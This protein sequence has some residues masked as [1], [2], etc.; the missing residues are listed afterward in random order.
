MACNISAI[1]RRRQSP[2]HGLHRALSRICPSRQS[3]GRKPATPASSPRDAS[4]VRHGVGA[5]SRT[6]FPAIPNLS[7]KIPNLPAEIP[8]LSFAGRG[9]PSCSEGRNFRREVWN[10]HFQTSPCKKEA[11]NFPGQVHPAKREASH[12]EE[13]AEIFAASL[14]H[15]RDKSG[16]AKKKLR[17]AGKKCRARHAEPRLQGAGLSRQASGRRSGRSTSASPHLF[18]DSRIKPGG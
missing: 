5:C 9:F 14:I 3:P 4:V 18:V 11:S 6:F 12:C 17:G 15:E 8:D 16:I 13:K 1:D 7:G 2:L 10:F